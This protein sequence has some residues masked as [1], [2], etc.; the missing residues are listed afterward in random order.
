VPCEG[1]HQV[2]VLPASGHEDGTVVITESD[3]TFRSLRRQCAP[4]DAPDYAPA[5]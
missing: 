4:N 3:K 1:G 2:Q 5:C